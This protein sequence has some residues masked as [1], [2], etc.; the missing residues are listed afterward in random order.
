MRNLFFALIVRK[1]Q[2]IYNGFREREITGMKK[3]ITAAM[4]FFMIFAS[5]CT[6]TESS[7]PAEEQT[8]VSVSAEPEKEE[9]PV[10]EEIIPGVY[11]C[12]DIGHEGISAAA[13]IGENAVEAL[14]TSTLVVHEDMTAVITM[15]AANGEVLELPFTI[16]A[17]AGVMRTDENGEDPFTY[18]DGVIVI[19]D[20]SDYVRYELR[21]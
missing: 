17:E 2:Y 4:A 3:I 7:K 8:A 1:K 21:N 11:A 14:G 18:A 5:G 20:E 9:A 15:T 6:P 13:E 10:R 12:T 19:G 16:D